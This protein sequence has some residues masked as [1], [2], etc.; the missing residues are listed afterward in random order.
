MGKINHDEL[1]A[2]LKDGRSQAYAARHFQVSEAA[3]CKAVKKLKSMDLPESV[4]KLTGKQ[5]VFALNMAEGRNATESAMVAYDCKS[6]EVAK[7]L[8]SRMAKDPDVNLAIQDLVAQEGIPKRRRVQRLRDMIECPDLAIVGRGLDMGFKLAGDYAPQQI[9][10]I[11]AAE[12]RALIA[13][14]PIDGKTA[15]GKAETQEKDG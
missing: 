7:A 4:G 6:R 9:E 13:S 2:M 15:E 12:I 5:R 11:S 3:I 14:L 1:Q 10:V 8:G